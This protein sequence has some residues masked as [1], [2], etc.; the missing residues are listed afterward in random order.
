VLKSRFKGKMQ[1][2]KGSG[3]K[4]RFKAVRFLK[5]LGSGFEK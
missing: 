4:S 5:G 1:V 3:V 2:L